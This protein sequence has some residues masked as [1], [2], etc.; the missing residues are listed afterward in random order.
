MLEKEKKVPEVAFTFINDN[1]SEEEKK[2][3]IENLIMKR[4]QIFASMGLDIPSDDAEINE[5]S[6]SSPRHIR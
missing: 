5:V 3:K 4:N 1:M 6:D 2:K